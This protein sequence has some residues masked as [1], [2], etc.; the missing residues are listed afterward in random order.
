ML[1]RDTCLDLHIDKVCIPPCLLLMLVEA[2]EMET[3]EAVV[4][5]AGMTRSLP[6]LN[7]YQ[8]AVCL[9]LRHI[10]YNSTGI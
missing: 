1:A 7:I 2:L 10:C 3:Y 6:V 9:S 4:P 8:H 5:E